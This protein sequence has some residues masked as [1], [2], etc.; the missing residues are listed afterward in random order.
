MAKDDGWKS[1][2][3]SYG[4]TEPQLNNYWENIILP[5]LQHGSSTLERNTSKKGRLRASLSKGERRVDDSG[6]RSTK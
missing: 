2:H 6:P 3:G 5:S 1:Y 4:F